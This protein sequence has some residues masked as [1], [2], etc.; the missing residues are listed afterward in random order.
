VG[1][2]RE[3]TKTNRVRKFAGLVAAAFIVGSL[4]TVLQA[5]PVV[6]NPSASGTWSAPGAWP[7]IGMHSVLTPQGKVITYGSRGT[8]QQTGLFEYDVWDP[9]GSAADGHTVLPNLTQTDLFCN[10]QI[11]M[12]E[13]GNVLMAS[14]DI[15]DPAIGRTKNIGNDDVNVLDSTTNALTLEGKLNRT[16]WYA[17]P[18]TLPSGHIYIA[19]GKTGTDRSEVRAPNGNFMLTTIDTSTDDWYYP[20]NFV[21]P[22]G[23]LFGFDVQG[24]VY[25]HSAD[26]ATR[27]YIGNLP[28]NLAWTS[29]AVMYEPGKVLALGGPLDPST[30]TID[31]TSG[32]LVTAPAG[33]MS[34]IRQGV[35]ATLLPDGKVLATGGSGVW[36]ELIDVNN[37]AEIWDPA[38]RVWTSLSAG[39]FARL[40]HS[41]AL[42]LP[43]GRV[44]VAGG[45]APGPRDGLDAE[46]FSP[47]YLFTP[48]GALA[49]RPVITSAPAIA[50]T[51]ATINVGLGATSPISRVT[52]VKTGSVT[53]SVNFD[54]RYLPA[55]FSQAGANLSVTLPNNSAELTP[56]AYMLFVFDAAGV[57]S[58]AKIFRVP[59]QVVAGPYG[60]LTGATTGALF[61]DAA[62]GRVLGIDVW[63]D[64]DVNGIRLRSAND[65]SPLRG[66]ATGTLTS[67]TLAANERVIEVSGR[68]E[69]AIGQVTVK[70]NLRTM[71]PLGSGAGAPFRFTAPGWFEISSLRGSVGPNATP[72]GPDHLAALGISI[73]E[74]TSKLI[75]I[76]PGRLLDS[77][78]GGTTVDGVSERIGLRLAGSVTELQV[79]GR[80]G[81]SADATSVVLNVTVTDPVGSGYVTVWPCGALQPNASNVNFA[82]GQTIANTV[83]SKVGSGGRV[84]VFVSASAHLVADTTG[85]YL[86][87]VFT[88]LDPARLLDSRARGSTVDDAQA[89]VGLRLAG[90]VTEVQ[91]TGRA[92]VPSAATA[93]VLNVTVT[94]PVG[95]GYVTVWPCGALQPNASNVNFSGGDTIANAVISK[96]GIGGRVCVYT[97]TATE[98]IV[99]VT[100]FDR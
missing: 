49:S 70:T 58:V 93:V 4:V 64:T 23:R 20:R 74:M 34:S 3:Q 73:R 44:L 68:G 5:P 37:T 7:L 2:T 42:L 63:A 30:F 76:E 53:H 67:I 10:L 78:L 94:D 13:N 12:P 24:Q 32:S 84:C 71:G 100:A 19:G 28:T 27:T 55:E 62:A 90:S 61:D 45:G 31:M 29:S 15:W 66:S 17:S 87:G 95:S 43:D 98:L 91:V 35:N 6:A 81:I 38:T 80:H 82:A 25:L 8:G 86:S 40:Y 72:G 21:L 65:T 97:Q 48:A 75:P 69:N 46:I 51:G 18:T 39:T 41:T 11:V 99:D 14:G 33:N 57:P 22:D 16:R 36:N 60:F 54:Q 89:R 79:T 92:G 9:S 52:L 77:R 47:P 26:L 85:Y 59:P 1:G 88:P 83:V 50:E 96:I 56:G